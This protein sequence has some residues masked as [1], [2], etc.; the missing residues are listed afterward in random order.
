MGELSDISKTEER[1][2]VFVFKYIAIFLCNRQLIGLVS[3]GNQ[4]ILYV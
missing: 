3:V 2:S 4:C 1:D